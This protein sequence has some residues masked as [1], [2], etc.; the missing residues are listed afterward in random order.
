MVYSTNKLIQMFFSGQDLEIFL[1]QTPH[2]ECLA[3]VCTLFI[4]KP[5]S[6]PTCQAGKK[7]RHENKTEFTVPTLIPRLTRR[8]LAPRAFFRRFLLLFSFPPLP[9]LS[10]RS[11][12]TERI[13]G[14]LIPVKF[15]LLR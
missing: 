1:T 9:P 13:P 10:L 2:R 3:A 4:L 15:Q 6:S 14:L 12:A 8:A 5:L 7:W 11:P